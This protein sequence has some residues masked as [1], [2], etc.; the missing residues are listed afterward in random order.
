MSF[1]YKVNNDFDIDPV[2]H[3]NLLD[4]NN[5]YPNGLTND[6]VPISVN[7]DNHNYNVGDIIDLDKTKIDCPSIN[8]GS[9]MNGDGN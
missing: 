5:D 3:A 9:D 1:D 7:A 4:F 2:K 8:R 6:D